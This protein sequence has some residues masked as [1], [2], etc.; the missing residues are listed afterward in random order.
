MKGMDLESEN[1]AWHNK[2]YS[3]NI[4]VPP[5]G[6]TFIKGKNINIL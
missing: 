1:I 2:Q 5:M 3:I 6:A 4:K